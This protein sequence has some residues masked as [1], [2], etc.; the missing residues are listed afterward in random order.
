MQH[1]LTLENKQKDLDQSTGDKNDMQKESLQWLETK[2]CIIL[3]TLQAGFFQ[4]SLAT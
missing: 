2:Q 4:G 3:A 1:F